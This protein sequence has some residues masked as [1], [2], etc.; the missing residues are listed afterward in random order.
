[1]EWAQ[2]EHLSVCVNVRFVKRTI[3]LHERVLGSA[4]IFGVMPYSV[5]IVRVIIHQ[6]RRIMFVMIVVA[7]LRPLL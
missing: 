5:D 6:P 7:G 1:V 4:I 2:I 3:Y